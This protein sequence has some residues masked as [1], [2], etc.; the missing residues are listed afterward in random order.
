MSLLFDASSIFEAIVEKKVS[1][2]Q[3]NYTIDLAVYEVGN[4]L[5]KR[6]SLLRDIGDAEVAKLVL[7]VKRVLKL[8]KKVKLDCQEEEIIKIAARL[9]VTFYDASYAFAAKNNNLTLVTEDE[10]LRER[11]KSYVNTLSLREI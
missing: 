10:K 5:W 4:T 9:G 1:V 2:L 8:L 7:L 6:M 3:G 11:A